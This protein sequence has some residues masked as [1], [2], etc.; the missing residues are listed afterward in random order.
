MNAY[1]GSSV[2]AVDLNDDGLSDLL[3][4]AP[5][6]AEEMDEGRVY[7]YTNR[8]VQTFNV[9]FWYH[10]TTNKNKIKLVSYLNPYLFELIFINYVVNICISTTNSNLSISINYNI[11]T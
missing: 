3:V 2:A 11:N 8:Q 6:Y 1:F 9:L 5:L 10:Y 7:V 4:G